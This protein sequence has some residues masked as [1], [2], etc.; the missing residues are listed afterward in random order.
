MEQLYR[1]FQKALRYLY[2]VGGKEC[3]KRVGLARVAPKWKG[4]RDD[5]LTVGGAKSK[6]DTD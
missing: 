6:G 1:N 3:L 2:V 4:D 5:L